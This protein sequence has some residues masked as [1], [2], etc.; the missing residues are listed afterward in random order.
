MTTI[1]LDAVA[2]GDGLGALVPPLSLAI[3]SGVV[4]VLAVETDERP[5]L[6]SM[7]L[8]GRYRADA[9]RI[10]IDGREDPKAL[11]R[12]VALV[13]TPFVVAPPAEIALSLVVAEEFSFSG[14]PSSKRHVVAFLRRHALEEY[15][16][17]PVRALPPAEH[18]RLFSEL[19]I[20][21]EGIATI[22]VTSPERHGGD[23]ADWYPAVLEIASRGIGVA[24]IT[25]TPTAAK[26]LALGARDA[27]AA[28]PS[29]EP[30]SD[31]PASDLPAESRTS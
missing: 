5:M 20:L 8:G 28:L 30:A 6:V 24:V 4:S 18:I 23:A 10:L 12:A 26:L 14:I 2:I 3:P 7:L 19:A 31:L 17:L 13:D 16:S 1:T 27:T 15:A 21:R 29:T 22:V 9:G 11:R 25:D